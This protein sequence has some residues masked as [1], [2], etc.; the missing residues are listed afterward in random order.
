MIH[1]N[2]KKTTMNKSNNS[3]RT[4]LIVDDHPINV[5]GYQA[6]LANIES[7]KDAE[8]LIAFDCK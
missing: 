7:N 4:I 8:Y 2:K 5:E 6:L 1:F 3:K